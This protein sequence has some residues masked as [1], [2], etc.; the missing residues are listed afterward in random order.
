MGMLVE[1]KWSFDDNYPRDA[2]GNFVRPQSKFRNWITPDGAP[3]PSGT[4]G[5]KAE[6]GRYHLYVA[7]VCPW[8]HRTRMYRVLKGLEGIVGLTVSSSLRPQD[9]GW[10]FDAAHP[11]PLH[12]FDFVHRLY[13]KADPA[14]TGRV[15]VPVLWDKKTN[16]VVSNESSE[17]VRMFNTAFDG[18]TGNRADFYPAPLRAE[19][20][21]TNERV[22]KGLNNGVYRA[23]GATTQGAYEAAAL[24]VFATLDWME[25]RLSRSRYLAGERVTEADWR[26]LPTLLRFDACYYGIMKCNRNRLIDYPHLHAYTRELWQWPGIAATLDLD[27]SRRAYWSNKERNPTGIV[28]IAPAGDF[29]AP[30]GRERLAAA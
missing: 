21:A 19:I 12:G 8:A 23:G 11:D 2:A 1:G 17:I 24:E 30:H 7:N 27:D 13:A 26:A 15:T 16:F 28:P 10:E 4:G 5:F 9:Q 22:Y 14:Y 20:D 25:E 29:N 18:V 3:G 6:A